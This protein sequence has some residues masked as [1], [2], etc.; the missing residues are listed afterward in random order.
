MPELTVMLAWLY[1]ELSRSREARIIK[2]RGFVQVKAN[3]IKEGFLRK[4]CYFKRDAIHAK[5]ECKS[6]LAYCELFSAQ[7]SNVFLN[8][9]ASSGI[10]KRRR[11][12]SGCISSSELSAMQLQMQDLPAAPCMRTFIAL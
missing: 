12:I 10:L 9:A 11:K 3:D 5:I 4:S 1:G 2:Y 6:Y 7:S 8:A